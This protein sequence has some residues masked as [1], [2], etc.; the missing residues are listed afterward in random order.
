[1]SLQQAGITYQNTGISVDKYNR[2]NIKNIFAIGDC[3]AGNPK[4]T[5]WANN[6]GR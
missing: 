1:M 6:E 2:T 4:F 3:V 5:H